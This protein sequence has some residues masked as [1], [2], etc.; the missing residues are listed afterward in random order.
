[1]TDPPC[2]VKPG[3]PTP[4]RFVP[5]FVSEMCRVAEEIPP[6]HEFGLIWVCASR[7]RELAE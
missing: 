1:M 6:Q 2:A 7:N 4:L 5:Y 3:L